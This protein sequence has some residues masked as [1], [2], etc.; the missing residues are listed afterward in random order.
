MDEILDS[1]PLE[2]NIQNTSISTVTHEELE[3]TDQDFFCAEKSL[4]K[5]R[6][7]KKGDCPFKR[8]SEQKGSNLAL[9]IDAVKST[10]RLLQQDSDEKSETMC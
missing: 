4:E 10:R 3:Q 1:I 5:D 7:P 9:E 2:S 6:G 8:E